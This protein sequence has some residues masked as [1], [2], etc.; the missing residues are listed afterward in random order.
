MRQVG[1]GAELALELVDLLDVGVGDR[2]ERDLLAA[3]DVVG[4]VHH[5]HATGANPP[6]HLVAID[7]AGDLLHR[8]RLMLLQLSAAQ[9]ARDLADRVHRGANSVPQAEWPDP[10]ALSEHRRPQPA[11]VDVDPLGQPEIGERDRVAPG[12]D[13]QREPG[14][15]GREVGVEPRQPGAAALRRGG[16]RRRQAQDHR[17][18]TGQPPWRH[19]RVAVRHVV[20]G[21]GPGAIARRGEE[22]LEA[23]EQ[24]VLIAVGRVVPGGQLEPEI[25][26]E[27]VGPGRVLALQRARQPDQRRAGEQLGRR[28]ARRQPGATHHALEV[29]RARAAH[30]ADQAEYHTEHQPERGADHEQDRQADRSK[31]RHSPR[32]RP[33]PGA[34]AQR[35]SRLDPCTAT[36][37]SRPGC[38][39]G[40]RCGV[41]RRD[42]YVAAGTT[43]AIAPAMRVNRTILAA[44][45]AGGTACSTGLAADVGPAAPP[46]DGAGGAGPIGCLS[47]SECPTGWTCNDFHVCVAPPAGSDGGVPA[48]TEIPLGPPISSQRFVYVAMTAQGKLARIDGNTLTVSTTP[49]GPAPREVATIPGSDG[50]VALDA[51][52]GTA[53]VVRPVATGGD[54]TRVLPTLPGLNRLDIDPTG[55]FAVIWFDLVR[56]RQDGTPSTGSF[57]D[58]VI[59][60]LAPGHETSVALTVGFRPRAV[61]FDAAGAHAFMIT[62]D[63]VSVID[64]A[65]AVG[66]GPRIVPPIAVAAPGVSPDDLEVQ[67]VATGDYAAVRQ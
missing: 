47:S 1:Q 39:S 23:A 29:H 62:E 10:A 8:L 16:R 43:V 41:P 27:H 6:H 64:L 40:T 32:H 13:H 33:P 5:A 30:Q 7:G 58:A 28:V 42:R 44:L 49:V 52:N 34:P 2:L 18:V 12:A 48:E 21:V 9:A 56:A 26:A 50:A 61:Q 46:G 59:A 19:R 63:G 17:P 51:V 3:L 53:T 66:H 11:V 22:R 45:A 25:E 36:P 65:D 37:A 57:Q 38:A 31:Q 14:A 54:G 67:I 55:R 24:Q 35:R 60:S 20:A 4:L 15:A